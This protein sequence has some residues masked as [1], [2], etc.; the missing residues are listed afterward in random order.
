MAQIVG[1]AAPAAITRT[2]YV[3]WGSVLAG[4]VAASSLSLL[5]LTFGGAIGLSISSP[6]PNSGAS[7]LTVA[8]IVGLWTAVVQVCSFA[9]GGYLAGRMRVSWADGIAT[10]R[11]FRDGAHGFLVWAVGVLFGAIVLALTGAGAIGTVTQSAS[12]IAG[13]AAAGA[14]AQ[15]AE[16]LSVKPA[17][18]A[19]DLLMRPVPR[20]GAAAP[21][22]AA[23]SSSDDDA[24]RGEVGR[25]YASA[26]TN[27]ELTA[28]DRDY[29]TRVVSN[30]TGLPEP[31]AQRRVDKSV[32]EL[33]NLE[34]RARDA[35]NKARKVA[36]ITGFVA[37]ATLLIGLGAA[38]VGAGAGGRHR[39]ENKSP[40]FFGHRFW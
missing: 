16:T 13:G 39:D 6:F 8:I 38:C 23:R 37:A 10:E 29:L 18:Y 2:S 35:A 25:I 14:S 36:L 5:M 34:T 1:A 3:D 19:V 28:R 40:E 15:A 32:T 21:P 11:E 33:R 24:L 27:R 9:A 31:E 30:R 4:A 7:A 20:S 17:D 12:T 22:A 26:V